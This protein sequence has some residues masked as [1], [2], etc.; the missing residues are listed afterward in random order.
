MNTDPSLLSG[1]SREQGLDAQVRDA[2]GNFTETNKR[3]SLV[4]PNFYGTYAKDALLEQSKEGFGRILVVDELLNDP[5]LE[6]ALSGNG[7]ATLRRLEGIQPSGLAL[8]GVMTGLKLLENEALSA[9][10][11]SSTYI[12]DIEIF[13]QL[14]QLYSR[15]WE[16]TGQIM[17]DPGQP[18]DSPLAHTA[19]RSFTEAENLLTL[20]PPFVK[21]PDLQGLNKQDATNAFINSLDHHFSVQLEFSRDP[22]SLYGITQELRQAAYLGFHQV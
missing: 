10:E 15:A 16:A 12:G 18:D 4:R 6:S 20:V 9:R 1:D 11:S 13:N 21:N 7:L 5:S 8:Y 2:V 19:L 17:L 22:G 3:F 14:G